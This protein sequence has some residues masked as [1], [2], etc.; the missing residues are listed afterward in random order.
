MEDTQTEPFETFTDTPALPLA[1]GKAKPE[2]AV[3]PEPEP[4]TGSAKTLGEVQE[5]VVEIAARITVIDGE[6]VEIEPAKTEVFRSEWYEGLYRDATTGKTK[7][8][9]TKLLGYP[10][11]NA[12]KTGYTIGKIKE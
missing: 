11:W 9:P 12:D 7:Q 1:T 5:V 3:K 4:K 6:P 10:I 8:F 2:K